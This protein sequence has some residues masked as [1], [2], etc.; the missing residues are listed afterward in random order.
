LTWPPPFNIRFG[1]WHSLEI[2]FIFGNWTAYPFGALIFRP[3]NQEGWEALSNSM[4]EYW[5]TF[6]RTGHPFDPTGVLW[7]PWSNKDGGLKRIL[8]DANAT[9][10]LIRMSDQ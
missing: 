1:A 8:L 7:R 3:D 4:V 6:A 10:T 2:P 9:Q 5:S